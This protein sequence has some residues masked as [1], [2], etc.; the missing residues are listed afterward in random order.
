MSPRQKVICIVSAVVIALG[1]MLPTIEGSPV[2]ALVG[3]PIAVVALLAFIL[4]V[5][6]ARSG[7]GRKQ[8]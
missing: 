1:V 8:D 5:A 2:P 7:S 4:V 3:V 6:S